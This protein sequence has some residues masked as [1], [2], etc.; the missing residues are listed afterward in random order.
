MVDPR[1]L[2]SLLDRLA[3]E[4]DELRTLGGVPTEELL[5][6]RIRL[7]A[8]KYGMVIAAEVCIDIGQHIASEG[9]RAPEDS[10]M[11]LIHWPKEGPSRRRWPLL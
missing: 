3:K 5:A 1:R 9:F 6:D 11:C 2:R 10:P 8:T 7:S 4:V